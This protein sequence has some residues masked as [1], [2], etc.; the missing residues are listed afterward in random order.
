M[1]LNAFYFGTNFL[2]A[3]VVS[4]WNQRK[5]GDEVHKTLGGVDLCRS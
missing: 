1:S 2:V 5:K 4:E 3:V